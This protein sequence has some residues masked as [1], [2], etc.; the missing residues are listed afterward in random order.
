MVKQKQVTVHAYN[1]P[2]DPK[3]DD[4]AWQEQGLCREVTSD[5][6]FY[7]EQERGSEKQSRISQAKAVCSICPV[8]QKCLDFS[9]RTNQTHGIW[10]GLTQDERK[11]MLDGRQSTA[12]SA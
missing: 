12:A 11:E 3:P 9:I 4:W 8:K 2:L 7:E 5:I 1:M 6:F 10:G